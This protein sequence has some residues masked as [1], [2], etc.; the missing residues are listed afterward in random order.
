[1]TAKKAKKPLIRTWTTLEALS[2]GMF[3]DETMVTPSS[4]LGGGINLPVSQRTYDAVLR[5]LRDAIAKEIVEARGFPINISQPS[6]ARETLPPELFEKFSALAVDAFG[7]TT[8]L[9][10]ASPQ[11]IP[12]WNGII[13]EEEDIRALWPKPRS[14]LDR[15]MRHSVATLPGEKRNSRISDCQKATGCTI[16]EAKAAHNRLPPDMKRGRGQR[17]KP[18]GSAK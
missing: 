15:W 13:F 1:M 10:P 4:L 11:I 9:H 2:W 5:E 18:P 3:G 8:L 12:Q 17:I 14:D 16:R 6:L 7:V